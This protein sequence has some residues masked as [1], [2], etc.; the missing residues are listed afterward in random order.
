M[1]VKKENLPLPASILVTM[2]AYGILS[3]VIIRERPGVIRSDFVNQLLGILPHA[4]AFVNA[5]ALALLIAGWWLIRN[6]YVKL[7][8]IVMPSALGLISVFLVMYVTRI[9]LGGIKEFPGPQIVYYYV[10]LPVLIIHLALSIVCIQP[11]LYVAL[12]GLTHRIEDIPRTKHRLVGRIAVPMW[13]LSLALGLV[14]YA[15]LY[16]EF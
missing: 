3:F 11:V 2:V 6:G 14:V 9:Y 15:M 8:R 5:L 16:R 10:Y 4:I 12:I 13:I 7:H 1:V